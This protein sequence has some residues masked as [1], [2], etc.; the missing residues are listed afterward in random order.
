M[1]GDNLGSHA[2]GGCTFS[3]SEYFCRFCTMTRS[4]FQPAPYDLGP[5]SIKDDYYQKKSNKQ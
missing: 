2:L 5:F 1:V 3:T 4:N